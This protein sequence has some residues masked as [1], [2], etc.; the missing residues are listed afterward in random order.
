MEVGDP[1][2][3]VPEPVVAPEV[4]RRSAGGDGQWIQYDFGGTAWL[5][6]VSIA[7]YHGDQRKNRFDLLTSTDGT[8]WRNSALILRP[9]TTYDPTSALWVPLVDGDGNAIM[10][11][12]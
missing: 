4:G 10:T 7:V 1:R 12:A 9:V 5:Q 11:E 6:T 8:A 3:R 2:A